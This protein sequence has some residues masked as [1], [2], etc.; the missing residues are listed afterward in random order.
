MGW[1]V[2][3][4]RPLSSREVELRME[5]EEEAPRIDPAMLAPES[6]RRIFDEVEQPYTEAEAVAEA[7]RCM[8]CGPC[9]E[10]HVCVTACDKRPAMLSLDGGNGRGITMRVSSRVSLGEDG[11]WPLRMSPTPMEQEVEEPVFRID[12][13]TCRVDEKLCRACGDCTTA[14]PYDIPEL[15]DTAGGYKATS[16]DSLLCR[17]CGACVSVCR[18]GAI[19]QGPYTDAALV[20]RMGD[21]DTAAETPRVVHFTCR[22]WHGQ[23]DAW[24]GSPLAEVEG[25]V[26][27]T[28]PCC[29]R[30]HS[31]IVLQAFA[32]GADG[33]MVTGCKSEL[34][35][36]GAVRNEP[37]HGV[38]E[39]VPLLKILG[40]SEDRF[41]VAWAGRDDK[42]QVE[43]EARKFVEAVGALRKSRTGAAPSDE[44]TTSQ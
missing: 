9:D 43:A 34:C 26:P 16:I 18:T 33:V 5:A 12:P 30:L 22:W 39:V 38:E 14:C 28:V 36:Y 2:P 24:G 1:Q 3:V 37:G 27:V 41:R 44:H 42:E 29:S 7:S 23:A 13:L 10:C 11:P 19:S 31:G 20:S 35:K 6:R 25:L 4:V 8:R 40:L 17:G 32:K 15:V 21:L